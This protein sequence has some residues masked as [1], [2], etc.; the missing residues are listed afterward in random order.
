MSDSTITDQEFNDAAQAVSQLLLKSDQKIDTKKSSVVYQ[1]LVRP[2]AYVYA[3]LNKLIQNWIFNTSIQHLSQTTDTSDSIADAVA[4]NYF[5]QRKQGR[6][7]QGSVVLTFSTSSG[8]VDSAT[9]FI[10]DDMPFYTDRTV[11]VAPEIRAQSNES[12]LYV[13]SYR[14]GT[15]YKA[16]IPVVAGNPGVIQIP[17]GVQVIFGGQIAQCTSAEV[18]SPISG[19]GA[20]QTNAQMMQRCKDKCTATVGTSRAIAAKLQEAPYPVISSKSLGTTDTGCLRA[21]DNNTLLPLMAA[22]DTYVKTRNQPVNIQIAVDKSDSKW[23]GSTTRS[24]TFDRHSYPQ[25]TGALALTNVIYSDSQNAPIWTVTYGAQE[26]SLLTAQTARLSK[27]QTITLSDI[28]ANKSIIAQFTVLPYIQEL[29]DY[30]NSIQHGF[31]GQDILV[32]A[33]IPIALKIECGLTAER[34]LSED[35]LKNMKQLVADLVNQLPVGQT[36]LNMDDIA[37]KFNQA[38]L[39]A[40]LKLPYTIHASMLTTN[41]GS[42]SFYT[43]SGTVDL[44]C[45]RTLYTWLPDAYYM[46]TTPEFITLQVL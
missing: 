9:K 8:R 45:R 43:V 12:V 15:S 34:L 40:T 5:V 44:S 33:A 1:L 2:Y 23:T 46:Y 25:I 18:Y 7:A 3:G 10:I 6:Y 37:A 31:I 14:F 32:K 20:V 19:G 27:Y 13:R 38:G 16:V 29:T 36:K 22:V 39:G 21:R 28:P 4:S 35:Q 41:G 17:A 26:G 42:Y 24:F 11:L 30:L